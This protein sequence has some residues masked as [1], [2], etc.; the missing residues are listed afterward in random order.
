MNYL[1]LVQDS[2]IQAVF[3]LR[4]P[5]KKL[6]SF[7]INLLHLYGE[8]SDAEISF[9]CGECSC[10]VENR[11]LETS[12]MQ[13]V[14]FLRDDLDAR[15]EISVRYFESGAAQAMEFVFPKEEAEKGFVFVFDGKQVHKIVL[16]DI[17]VSVS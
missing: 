16:A 2:S 11:N 12:K 8:P 15:G 4:F 17:C 5:E 10:V 7:W 3:D 9:S 13:S 6:F 1:V 14:S